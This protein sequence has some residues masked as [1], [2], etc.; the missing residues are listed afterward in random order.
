[1]GKTCTQWSEI[2][3]HLSVGKAGYP[4]HFT[5]KKG[6]FGKNKNKNTP[7]SFQLKRL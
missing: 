4:L 1:M 3:I 2:I 7:I 5:L 6:Y